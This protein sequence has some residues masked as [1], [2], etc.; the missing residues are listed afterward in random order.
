[1]VITTASDFESA[2]KELT[3]SKPALTQIYGEEMSSSVHNKIFQDIETELNAMYEQL[4]ILEDI[5]NYCKS[6]I[7]KSVEEEK[8]K[9]MDKL[10]VIEHASDSFS[11]TS[12]VAYE[13]ELNTASDM[14]VRDR[15]G[16][17]LP[18][19]RNIDGQLEVDGLDSRR[20]TISSIKCTTPDQCY[21][22]TAQNLV[23]GNAAR[24][25]YVLG[26]PAA[27]G[28]VETY[29]VMFKEPVRCNH[30]NIST[31]NCDAEKFEA[32]LNTN[33]TTATIAASDGYIDEMQ[34][35]GL[36]FSV[37]ATN[38]DYRDVVIDRQNGNNFFRLLDDD[39]YKRRN[40]SKQV[41]AFVAGTDKKNTQRYVND[42]V[43]NA[44][45]TE[46]SSQ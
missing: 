46:R 34:I 6:S 40:T 37:R 7:I 30:I 44:V 15:N 12:C 45:K 11:D 20:G 5:K 23:S 24:S 28:V 17:I 43:A 18:A 19:M 22:N 35:C 27:K 36:R 39:Y 3:T 4:R 8:I 42:F 38:Y 9:L 31:V 41:T 2:I 13:V 16:D 10:R 32:F 14:E 26:E 25:L 29:E 33:G 21:S 1:M